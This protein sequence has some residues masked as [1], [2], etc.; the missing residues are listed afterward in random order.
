MINRRSFLRALGIASA[1]LAVNP[2]VFAST[3]PALKG[4][5]F[6]KAAFGAAAIDLPMPRKWPKLVIG[7]TG[8]WYRTG[9]KRTVIRNLDHWAVFC[10]KEDPFL[11]TKA[12]LELFFRECRETYS[13][14]RKLSE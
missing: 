14:F 6:N 12:D 1:A 8:Q 7:H 9:P 11:L 5:Y 3:Q 10:Q 2:G 4:L 13:V